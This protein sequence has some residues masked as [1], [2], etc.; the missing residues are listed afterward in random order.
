M[1]R[2]TRFEAA[3]DRRLVKGLSAGN[4]DALA[5]LYDIYAER[6]FDYCW[7]SLGDVR[8][9]ANIVHDTL[10]DAYRRAGRMR[11]RDRLRAWL[12]AA[13]RRRCVQQRR[14]GGALTW[15]CT[16]GAATARWSAFARSDARAVSGAAR[17]DPLTAVRPMT[18]TGVV[19]SSRGTGAAGASRS[20]GPPESFGAVGAPNGKKPAATPVA[21]PEAVTPDTKSADTTNSHAANSDAADSDAASHAANSDATSPDATRLDAPSPEATGPSATSSEVVVRLGGASRAGTRA[22]AADE[23]CKRV[24]KAFHRLAPADQEAI[25][26]A[27]RHDLDVADLVV[28]LG[29]SQRRVQSRLARARAWLSDALPMVDTS[30]ALDRHTA[31]QLPPELRNR[32][33][34]A[35]SDPELA[36]YR[37]D[38]VARAG[39][40]SPDGF[41]RQPGSRSPLARR[42]LF[43]GSGLS[44]ALA[45]VA[46]VLMLLGPAAPGAPGPWPFDP[47]PSPRPSKSVP[48]TAPQ[49]PQNPDRPGPGGG[50]Q[51]HPGPPPGGAPGRPEPEHERDRPS[52]PPAG[53]ARLTVRPNEI[54]LAGRSEATI[55]LR[56]ENADVAWTARDSAGAI[57]LSRARGT[58][59][60]GEAE[61]IEVRLDRALV[62]FPGVATVTVT[63]AGGRE[64]TVQVSWTL[65]LL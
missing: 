29:E 33:L 40:L 5:K 10:I 19:R 32:V 49:P 11:D 61:T 6:L 43:A 17:S 7:S 60:A 27:S 12:Y 65:S 59:P 15:E 42:W 28:T 21:S 35:G 2:W 52:A 55:N 56:A 34:H 37:A 36:G 64:H 46:A 45:G 14:G 24:R 47:E 3:A 41:P 20:P 1:A 57:S 53:Q 62:T 25:F 39:A 48:E 30:T 26:L 4:E 13:A 9:S 44:A 51:A 8:G 23:P 63:E 54:A 31:P 58:A 38:I 16:G 22:A 50:E 18:S